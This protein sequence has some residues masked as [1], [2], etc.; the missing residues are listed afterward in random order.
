MGNGAEE[1]LGRRKN[2]K[3]EDKEGETNGIEK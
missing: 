3:G 2:K 1:E